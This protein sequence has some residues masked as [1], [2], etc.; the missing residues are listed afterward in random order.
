MR[1]IL[2]VAGGDLCNLVDVSVFLTDMDMYSA[3]NEVYN[4]YFDAESGPS[5]TTVGV[6]SLP[7]P[8]LLIEIKGVAHLKE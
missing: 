3:F 4:Q 8:H 1:S 5:R 2:K 7:G 6:A